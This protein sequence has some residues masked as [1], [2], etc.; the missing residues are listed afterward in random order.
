M[1]MSNIDDACGTFSDVARRSEYDT[2]RCA[3]GRVTES[4]SHE[5]WVGAVGL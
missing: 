2:A 3:L 4:R 1:Q 5:Y